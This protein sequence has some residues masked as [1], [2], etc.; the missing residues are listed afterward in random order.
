M[1]M[2][3]KT[4]LTNAATAAGTLMLARTASAAGAPAAQPAAGSK[5]PAAAAPP[6]PPAP[7]A[8]HFPVLKPAEFEQKKMLDGL[9]VKKEHKL[10]FQSVEPI[11]LLPGLSS[12]FVH[13]QNAINAGEFSMGWGKGNCAT[14]AVLL[15][16][17]VIL[18]LNDAM[19]AKYTLGEAFGIKD[20]AGKGETANVFYKAQ[21][22]M[23]FEGDPGA[24]GNV[25]QDWSAEACVKR[26]TM[27]MVCHNAMVAMAGATAGKTG[28][29]PMDILTEWKANMNPGF[30]L[31]PAGVGALHVAMENGWKMIPII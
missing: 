30:M 1:T 22:A 21:T 27:L 11:T 8:V 25:Y 29:K 19:W 12:L 6:P 13:L 10:V 31:V 23:A 18:G 4:F 26:G 20:A 5:A 15:G 7:S 3:R 14:A 9:K 24:G 16:P 2:S 28:G 17:S